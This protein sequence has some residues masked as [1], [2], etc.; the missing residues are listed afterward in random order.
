MRTSRMVARHH[1]MRLLVMIFAPRGR[2]R[3]EAVIH[4]DAMATMGLAPIEPL[5][6]TRKLAPKRR[7]RRGLSPS[8]LDRNQSVAD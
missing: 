7:P 4:F 1:V 8:S 6:K 2:A 3:V 5:I